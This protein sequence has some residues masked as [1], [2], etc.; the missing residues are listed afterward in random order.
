MKV[1]SFNIW[2]NA[3][4]NARWPARRDAVVAVLRSV[5]PDVAGLQEATLPMVRDLHERLPGYQWVG[6]GRDDGREV[7][8]FTPIFFRSERFRVLQ[9]SSFWLSAECE[10]PGR[11]W[12]AMHSRIV[13]W[14]RFSDQESGRPFL[15]FNTHLDHFG[16]RARTHS[17]HLLRKKMSEIR[18]GDPAVLTGDFNCRESS[19]PYRILT[20]KVPFAGTSVASPEWRDTLYHTEHPREGPSRTF[21][22]IMSL[23]GL[24]RLDYILVNE[25]F[26]TLRHAVIESSTDT[27]DHRPVVAELAFAT[28]AP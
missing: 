15:F 24:A 23:F 16:L 18:A 21:F 1:C 10:K 9:Q 26:R 6:V 19:A 11:G 8:E 14:A 17:A 25:G 7:G 20:G 13:T 27:S 12:D 22:G 5:A 4:R 2:S 28:D 3:P